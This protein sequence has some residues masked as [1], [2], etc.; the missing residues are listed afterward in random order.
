MELLAALDQSFD[1]ARKI[2]GGVRADQYGRPTPCTEWD[3]RALLGH[4]VGVMVNMERG[5]SGGELLPDMN[6]IDLDDD[7]AAQFGAASERTLAAW[8]T[9][10]LDGEVN[11]GAGAMPAALGAS[12]NLVD[13]TAHTWDLARATG[14]DGAIPDSLAATSLQVAE[15][16]VDGVRQFA[17]IA[18]A[19]AVPADAS[20]TARFVAYMGRQP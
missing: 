15:G 1:Q 19:I 3:V 12:I 20:P 14:Q 2:V 8:R 4:M 13:T 10:G 7:V 6:N 11:V 5:V 16:F 17:G 9:N 18:P